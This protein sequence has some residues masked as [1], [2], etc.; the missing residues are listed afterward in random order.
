MA[1]AIITADRRPTPGQ[2][3]VQ[4]SQGLSLASGRRTG[5]PFPRDCPAMEVGWGGKRGASRTSTST[6]AFAAAT[7]VAVAVGLP[8][9]CANAPRVG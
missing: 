6:S 4:F 7:A 8:A 2:E 3:G 1:R 5:Q 9:L